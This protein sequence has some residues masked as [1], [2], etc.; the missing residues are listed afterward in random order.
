M[1][2][3]GERLKETRES[4]GISIEE[5]SEDLKLEQEQIINIENGNVDAFKDIFNLKYFIRDYAKY[6]GLDKEEIVDDFNEYLF[7]Y[8]SKLSLE[9][10]KKEVS[11]KDEGPRIQSPYTLE[12]KDERKK[13]IMTYIIMGIL[14][15]IISYFVVSMI[16]DKNDDVDQILMGDVR[17][18][19]QINWQYLEF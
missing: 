17:W 5:V 14:L 7:D 19:Y 11:L 12:S 16:V 9:D 15:L 3:I 8:T 10:I 13:L 6:L 4:I 2:E 1:K 18:I